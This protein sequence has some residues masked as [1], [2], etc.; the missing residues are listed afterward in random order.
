M[1]LTS[2]ILAI[3]VSIDSLSVG[4]IY[5]IKGIK[6]PFMSRLIIAF[7]TFISFI[8]SMAFGVSIQTY[9]SPKSAQFL[10]AIILL[11]MGIWLLLKTI[12]NPEN[13]INNGVTKTI[14]TFN[15]KSL[16]L[17]IKILREPISADTDTSGTI[18]PK[19]ATLLGVALALD[20]FGAGIGAA[21]A[22]FNILITTFLV[23]LS[24][25]AFLSL[26]L[27]LGYQKQL[28]LKDKKLEFLPAILLI[29]LAVIKFF[30]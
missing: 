3:A 21:I 24:S 4:A 22:G 1:L 20:A 14:A 5:G 17:V 15:I 10:G 12:I 29:S 11:I 19:E 16:G 28:L 27:S 30:Y 8:I 25:L 6:I 23:T 13:D 18:D 2:I 7:A 9:L 26:G